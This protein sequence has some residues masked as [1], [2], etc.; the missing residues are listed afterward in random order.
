VICQDNR[1]EADV[2]VDWTPNDLD[3]LR[4]EAH[5]VVQDCKVGAQG[6]D[7]L[8]SV[9]ESEEDWK[10]FILNSGYSVAELNGIAES[11]AE[12]GADDETLVIELEAF[13]VANVINANDIAQA[14]RTYCN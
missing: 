14:V 12:R 6:D 4:H 13:A 5:H 10:Q 7:L 9:F 8:G 1:E 11:Y 3:T 2:E